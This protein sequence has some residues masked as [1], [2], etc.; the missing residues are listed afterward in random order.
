MTSH[1]LC[2]LSHCAFCPTGALRC[3]SATSALETRDCVSH[4]RSAIFVS[5]VHFLVYQISFGCYRPN[6]H[7]YYY[8]TMAEDFGEA[9]LVLTKHMKQQLLVY[10]K[11]ENPGFYY[12][13][14]KKSTIDLM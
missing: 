13:F 1:L 3:L 2:R 11:A 14:E 12:S 5:Q 4:V 9:T 8:K 7:L 6:Y 10:E